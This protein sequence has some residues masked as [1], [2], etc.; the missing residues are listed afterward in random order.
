MFEYTT[1]FLA[2]LFIIFYNI[3]RHNKN[4]IIPNWPIIGMVPSVLH[5]QSKI[6]D[7][8]TLALK[9]HRGTFQF[10][11]PWFTNI[12]TFIITSD[13]MNVNHI[14][15]KKFSNYGKGSDFLEIF[16][17][18]GVGIFNLDSKEW[19]QERAL[20]HSLLKTK[21]FEIF[22]QQNIQKKLE[23]C[24]LPFLDHASKEV[25]VLD[26]QDVLERFTFDISCTFFFGFDP[27][28]LPYK[29][30][31]LS[32][33]AYE[34]AFSVLEDMVLRR[35]YIPKCIW[36]LQKWL[37]IGLEKKGKAARE[38]LHQF[39]EKCITDYKGNEDVDESRYCLLKELMK[40][41]LG[42]GEMIDE[43]YIRDT[44]VNLFGAGNGT[45]SSGLSWF[46]WLVSTHP[47]GEAKIIQEIKDNCLTQEENL[48]NNLNVEKIDK[49]VYLHG[50]I[51]ETLR[52]YPPL[53]FQH[54]CAIKSDILPSGEH[55]GPNTKLIYSLYAMGRMQQIWGDDCLE[56][57][58]E[59]W[60]SARGG[61]INV[62][63]YKFIAFN[64]G[65]R[66]CIGK[67]LSFVQMKMVAA[68][69]LW[70]FRIQVVEG[71][72]VTLRTSIVVRMKHGLKVEVSKRCI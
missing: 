18:L 47:I 39:L 15:S 32:D 36:K 21:N 10:K 44:A 24:L 70:K 49:L 7:F 37:Q 63:S 40:E 56:F 68:S 55:V 14:L 26:L 2:I 45:I 35:H 31:E 69:L 57:K 41:R 52:L 66:S 54:K 65:P 27:N 48:I 25:K 42:K 11:G 8:V 20:L 13:P 28:C 43:K 3:W 4:K 72:P 30:N 71:H 38:N 58:P 60:I 59:R 29:C 12:A 1:F 23:N 17:I 22:Y 19:E 34:K 46:F 16:E 67:D 5:N 33:I 50:A 9:H 53:A 62:P 51:C 64:A 61:I 6:H